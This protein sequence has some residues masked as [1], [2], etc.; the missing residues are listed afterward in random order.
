MAL[1][2]ASIVAW[3]IEMQNRFVIAIAKVLFVMI[4]STIVV[5]LGLVG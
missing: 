4:L 5:K 1:E 3:E 2:I